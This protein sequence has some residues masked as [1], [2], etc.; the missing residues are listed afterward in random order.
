MGKYVIEIPKKYYRASVLIMGTD[1]GN[2]ITEQHERN[3]LEELTA[4]YV[5]EHFPELTERA[6]ERGKADAVEDMN[7][8]NHCQYC[9]YCDNG[10]EEEPCRSCCYSHISMFKQK[11]KEDANDGLYGMIGEIVEAGYS[12]DSVIKYAEKMKGE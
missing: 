8:D 3:E 6:Y 2:I 5:N 4:E 1:C 9:R 10:E 7:M 11:Q 12:I